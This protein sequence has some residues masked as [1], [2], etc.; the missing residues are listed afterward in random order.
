MIKVIQVIEKDDVYGNPFMDRQTF[1]INYL[2]ELREVANSDDY[3]QMGYKYTENPDEAYQPCDHRELYKL[4]MEDCDAKNQFYL[5]MLTELWQKGETKLVAG[6]EVRIVGDFAMRWGE[7]EDEDHEIHTIELCDNYL[8][9]SHN[10]VSYSDNDYDNKQE[11][12]TAFL[13]L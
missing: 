3:E 6:K 5:E 4:V 1:V 11:A 12:W 10:Q 2:Q 9:S 8:V 13:E 7:D